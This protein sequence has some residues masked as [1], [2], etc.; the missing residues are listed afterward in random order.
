MEEKRHAITVVII[1]HICM[2]KYM[3]NLWSHDTFGIEIIER[4]PNCTF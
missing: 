1:R 3:K 2:N 4:E